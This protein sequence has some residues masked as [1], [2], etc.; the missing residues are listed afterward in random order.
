LDIG[1]ACV[2]ITSPV[3]AVA[4]GA[5]V[6]IAASVTVEDAVAEGVSAPVNGAS[7]EHPKKAIKRIVPPIAK[8]VCVNVFKRIKSRFF[9]LT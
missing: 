1:D 9:T 5:D 8:D 2:T 7:L 4:A 3:S 6:G